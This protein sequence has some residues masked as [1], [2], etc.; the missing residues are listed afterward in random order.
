MNGFPSLTEEEAASYLWPAF[1]LGEASLHEFRSRILAFYELH[2]RRFIWRET[3]DPYRILLSEVM[4]QQTQTSRVLPKYELFL[5]LWPTF[6][7]LA[8]GSLDAL[9]YHWKGLGYNR[10]ALNLRKSAK[11]TESW[12]WTI[13]DD[14]ALIA[15]LP[16]VGKATAAALLAFCYQKKSIYLETNIRRVLLTCFF[17]HQEAVKDRQLEELLGL[18]AEGVT[19]MKS[20]YYA[21]MDY[22]VLL[23]Q[24]LPNANVRSAHY[25]K[26]SAFENSNRQIRGQLIHLLSD[27]GAK[28]KDHIIALLSSFDEERIHACLQQLQNEGF[29]QE[30]E[31]VYRIAKD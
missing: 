24:L 14:P 4:L 22:G 15:T 25:T 2:G 3:T 13:P 18:L 30:Q 12:G 28:E 21:L 16:G 20:W 23:K 26:Q 6:A 10:R 17:P 27:T 7:D 31:G 19:D 9:L 1:T 11:M 8:A 29:V 5:T